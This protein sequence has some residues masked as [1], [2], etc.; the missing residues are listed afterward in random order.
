VSGSTSAQ[1]LRSDRWVVG[2]DE[3]ALEH[4][5]ALRSAGVAVTALG[6]RPI[7]GIADSSSD[8]NPC[9]LPLRDLVPA[10]R[11]GVEDAGGLAVVFP[12]MSLGEDLM[13]PTAMLYRNL[14]AM[15]VEESIRS[16]PLDGVVLLANCDKTVP[17]ALMGAASAGLPAL[18]VTGG[19]RPPCS[20]RGQRIGTGT[21]LWRLWDLRRQGSLDDESW[22][23]L[24]A[25]MAQGRGAC[26]TMGTASTM[27]V[28]CEVLGF[29]L[30]GSSTV[31]SGG[32][33][34][35]AFAYSAGRR[36]VE[37]VREGTGPEKLCTGASVRNALIVLNAIAGSTNAVLHLAAICG[38]LGLQFD[39]DA[40]DRLGR[41]VPVIADVE[42]AGTGLMADLDSAGGVPSL[43]RVLA[44]FLEGGTALADGRSLAEVAAAAPA[45]SGP[46]I[47]ELSNPLGQDGAFRVVHGNLAPDGALLKLPT[48]SP[49]LL[50]HRGKA[51]V[52]NSYHE[53]RERV[54]DPSLEVDEA[55]V[56]VLSGCGPVGGPGM[57]EWAMV[58][59]PRKLLSSGV[60]DVVRLSDA[61]M[62]GT[63]FGTVFLHV[64]PEGAVGGP[65]GLV[66]DGDWVEVDVGSGR[67]DLLV[68]PSTL[69]ERRH[70]FSPPRRAE[71]GWTALY[72]AHVTQAPSGC[73]LDF[74]V[75]PAGQRPRLEEPVV[76]RS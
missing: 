42:P 34:L 39:L 45:P 32:R 66:E 31:P 10:V 25:C 14:V 44:D 49:Q 75:L 7:I 50:K 60:T 4:R 8:L 68:E 43:L 28:L 19:S 1:P 16:Y 2:D 18:M 65:I 35:L 6:G 56:L 51:V 52:F 63:S 9:N 15:E 70:T 61:R 29:S 11:Q 67:L 74:L 69:A 71:R 76:G 73:D 59:V 62:S 37:L 57:P 21:D 20:F 55:S 24:E 5:V 12:T 38:R 30:P 41:G 23:E 64:A 17:A 53:M 48:A 40:V 33:R 46:A 58:P 26:N 72:Q 27:A 47:R 3:A 13:M 22:A 54:E 36:A